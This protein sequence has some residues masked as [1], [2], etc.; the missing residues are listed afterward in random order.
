[1]LCSY[2]P[3]F[4]KVITIFFIHKMNS[5][6]C[7]SAHSESKTLSSKKKRMH[8]SSSI[9]LPRTTN[10][11]TQNIIS[12]VMIFPT[13]NNRKDAF[14]TMLEKGSKRHKV[15]FVDSIETP[16]SLV[17]YVEYKE[18][19]ERKKFILIK[20]LKTKPKMKEENQNEVYHI[21]YKRRRTNSI[22]LV[23]V[24]NKDRVNCELCIV[25]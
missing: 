13:R 24:K 8:Q 2:T 25:F 3:Q 14:G 23:P 22:D 17:E 16:K 6:D 20:P 10:D 15:S 7:N 21:N 12:P 5:L 19:K 11:C 4:I 18:T 1:M 9:K